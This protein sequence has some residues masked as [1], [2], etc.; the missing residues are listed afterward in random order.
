MFTQTHTQNF[1]LFRVCFHAS[2]HWFYL[3]GMVNMNQKQATHK[4]RLT[5]PLDSYCMCQCSH[6]SFPTVSMR[7][8]QEPETHLELCG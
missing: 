4:L 2:V 7:N 5:I 1:E 8:L 6:Y 3:R